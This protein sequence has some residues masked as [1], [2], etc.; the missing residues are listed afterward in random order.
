MRLNHVPDTESVGIDV[1][2]P[3]EAS[4]GSFAAQLG[5]GVSIHWVH[6]DVI[7]V[8]REGLV[9]EVPLAE[10]YV[11]RRFPTGDD[12]LLDTLVCRLLRL[13]CKSRTRCL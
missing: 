8:E 1:E 12:D 2:P 9:L 5:D 3:C 13:R 7:L 6:V 10:A 11:V 4:S